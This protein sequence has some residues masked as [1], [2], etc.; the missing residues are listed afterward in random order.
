MTKLQNNIIE[1]FK[2]KETFI[3]WKTST[4]GHRE[5][6]KILGISNISAAN[7]LR[8]LY[9]KNIIQNKRSKDKWDEIHYSY[10]SI[11]KTIF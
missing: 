10:N 9:N 5:L 8:S 7:S 2:S 6:A 4:V 11:H 1:V 3:L